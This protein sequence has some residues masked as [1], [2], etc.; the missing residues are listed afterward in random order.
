MTE[1]DFL[2][3]M[4]NILDCEE[5]VTM[6]TVLADIEEWDSLSKVAVVAM[7]KASFGKN[8]TNAEVNGEKTIADVY[9][10]VK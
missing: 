5:E 10:M 4:E 3:K 2:E 8:L 9:G 6:D 7:A 1:K